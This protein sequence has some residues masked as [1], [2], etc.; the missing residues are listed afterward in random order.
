LGKL[1]EIEEDLKDIG[2]QLIAIAPDRPEEMVKTRKKEKAKYTLLCDTKMEAAR[3]YG[4]AF[5]V[6]DRTYRTYKM[7]GVDL[8]K[9]SGEKHHQLPV[10]SVFIVGKD[11]VIDFVHYNPDY[12]KRISNQDLKNAAYEFMWE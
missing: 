1:Q 5:R 12:T 8:E 11:K 4:V 2:F 3:A 9:Y 7:A 10:P 6:D